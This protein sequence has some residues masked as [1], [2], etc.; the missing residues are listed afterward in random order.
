MSGA[1]LDC[2]KEEVLKLDVV[3]TDIPLLLGLPIMKSL[4]LCI[5]YTKAAKAL[6]GVVKVM[7]SF[8]VVEVLI[9]FVLDWSGQC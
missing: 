1:H 3:Q 7:T 8:D 6:K 2:R 9:I 5:Q 4:N